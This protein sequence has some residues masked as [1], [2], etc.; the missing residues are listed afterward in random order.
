VP[1]TTP[2]IGIYIPSDGETGYGASFQ[3]GMINIDQHDHSGGPNKGL[4]I[5]PTIPDATTTSKGIAQ[6][7]GDD[8]YVNAGIVHDITKIT[9]YVVST[10]PN[11]APYITIQSAMDAANAAGGGTVWCRP[12]TYTE[13]L[14]FY[15]GVDLVASTTTPSIGSVVITGVHVPPIAGVCTIRNCQLVSATNIFLS[16]AG[17]T[18]N[19]FIEQCL[20]SVTNG[21]V[22]NLSD[23]TGILG[24]INSY[25]I[26]TNDGFV[27]NQHGATVVVDN[28]QIGAGVG[29]VG[30]ITGA[31]RI[32]NS[33]VNCPILY[34]VGASGLILSSRVSQT[35]TANNN[36]V[37]EFQN[38]SI[39]TGA[40]VAIH[41]DSANAVILA[42]TSLYSTVA[43]GIVITG[44]GT[45][46]LSTA[47]F[48]GL[49]GI[50]GTVAQASGSRLVTPVQTHCLAAGTVAW[51]MTAAGERT[52]P[53]Q[54]A[55]LAYLP[56]SDNAVTGNVTEYTLGGT[57]PLTEI[58]DQN[59]DFN[60]N[61]TFTGPVTGRY[62]FN[63]VFCYL[64]Q[65]GGGTT[66]TCNL[67]TSNRDYDG[68][69]LPTRIWQ[70]GFQG[71]NGYVTFSVITFAD[72]DAGDTCFFVISGNGGNKV[73]DIVGGAQALSRLSGELSC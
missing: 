25:S 19:I 23:W 38:S 46:N 1:T 66:V 72:M 29:N 9:P 17:G 64:A 8:F 28:S 55:F 44:T 11:S 52:M 68:T 2:N 73:D 69:S 41:T 67:R 15:D 53:L 61:G 27:T 18:A 37:L 3:S 47:T 60:V 20:T 57:T 12:G 32:N 4:P 71:I 62:S 33:L 13:N 54:P 49:F 58:Y 56:S 65:A 24:Y 48:T 22:F 35:T 59:N 34:S 70:A 50:S 6:F 40:T 14:Q 7:D 39:S 51:N 26:S 45:I 36:A 10:I 16:V 31:F 30:N 42:N 43:G 63:G 5:V 21:Y